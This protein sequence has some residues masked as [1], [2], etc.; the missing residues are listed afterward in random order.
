MEGRAIELYDQ[1]AVNQEIDFSDP[2]YPHPVREVQPFAPEQ[3]ADNNFRS[4][5]RSPICSL[6]PA[7][8]CPIAPPSQV[9]CQ[10]I[11]FYLAGTQSGFS[12]DQRVVL[13]E[14]TQRVQHDVR[15][16]RDR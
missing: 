11:P 12:D 13:R 6:E 2:C 5:I 8:G 7:K 9:Q 4:R 15:Q 16:P 10:E 14:A 3:L 1:P